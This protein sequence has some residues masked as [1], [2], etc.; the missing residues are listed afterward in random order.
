MQICVCV[1]ECINIFM[2]VCVNICLY[3][4]ILK[5]KSNNYL[6]K[7]KHKLKKSSN[8]IAFT[9][10]VYFIWNFSPL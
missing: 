2:Y 10:I 1:S 7:K 6:I 9:S 5:G 3:D 4:K 8:E